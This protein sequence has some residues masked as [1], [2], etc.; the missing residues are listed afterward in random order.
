MVW[1]KGIRGRKK[2]RTS[3]R[4]ETL[5]P[6]RLLVA[7]L[8][9]Q[10]VADDL[11]DTLSVQDVSRTRADHYLVLRNQS[12][13]IAASSGVLANDQGIEGDNLS[14]V[15]AEV[16]A[17]G[18]LELAADGAF[19][20]EPDTGFT[21]TDRFSYRATDG[22]G[23]SPPTRVT[24][25]VKAPEEPRWRPR[26]DAVVTFNEVMYHPADDIGVAEWIELHNQVSVNVDISNWQALFVSY[27]HI[28]ICNVS[29][30]SPGPNHMTLSG[31]QT[32]KKS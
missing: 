7:N 25:V 30:R 20:F 22:Q 28:V 18:V 4:G 29:R 6:R 32:P 23:N 17:H 24:L 14:A 15:L 3:Q 27:T 13:E 19:R 31:P 2:Q 1:W 21:G 12:L 8:L 10:R 16:P 9:A 26:A 5:E 11:N